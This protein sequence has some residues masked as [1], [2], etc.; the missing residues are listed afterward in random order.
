M[1]WLS[2][3]SRRL[4]TRLF[5]FVKYTKTLLER[6]QHAKESRAFLRAPRARPCAYSAFAPRL[7]PDGG[8]Y[9]ARIAHRRSAFGCTTK[10]LRFKA[11]QAPPGFL[12]DGPICTGSR[13]ALHRVLRCACVRPLRTVFKFVAIMRQLNTKGKQNTRAPRGRTLAAWTPRAHAATARTCAGTRCA[14]KEA[15]WHKAR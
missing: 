9:T 7:L 14:A 12:R 1:R 13:D 6:N 4:K 2:Q 10:P 15:C 8:V 3:F 11:H 5:K